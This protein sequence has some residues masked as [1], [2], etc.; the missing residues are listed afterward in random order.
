VR[1][2][3]DYQRCRYPCR[4]LTRIRISI[5]VGIDHAVPFLRQSSYFFR[6]VLLACCPAFPL[7]LI[8]LGPR[9]LDDGAVALNGG[10]RDLHS[11]GRLD[12]EFALRQESELARLLGQ[13]IVDAL[14]GERWYFFFW[15]GKKS[16][17]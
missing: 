11:L 4:P 14:V 10:D 9:G 17:A 1:S 13:V 6:E 7:A 2:G 12:L 5:R 15:H 8:L 3:S 16:R